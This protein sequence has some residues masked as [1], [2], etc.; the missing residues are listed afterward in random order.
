MKSYTAVKKRLLKNQDVRQ[1]YRALGPDFA[2]IRAVIQKRL[3]QGMTQT[4]LARK[5]GT[6]QSAI[7]R[8]ESG[9]YNP[10]LGFLE[11]VAEALG[12]KLKVSIF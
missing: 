5:I 4:V 7:A 3:K 12:A 9:R 10:T 11:K 1:A 6:K 2:I 8:L